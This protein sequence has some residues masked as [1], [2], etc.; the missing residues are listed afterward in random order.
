MTD[1]PRPA[2]GAVCAVFRKASDPAGPEVLLV[3]RRHDPFA[4]TW[5]LPGGYLD[6]GEGP[7]DAGPRELLE[8][9]GMRADLRQLRVYNEGMGRWV[10]VCGMFGTVGDDAEPMA[11]DD[12]EDARWWRVS[13][14]GRIRYSNDGRVLDRLS[15]NHDDIVR[16]ALVAMGMVIA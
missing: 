9:T 11:G 16:D 1:W 7:D 13:C 6:E 15:F 5:A 8:E 12:A 4:G 14:L 2:V 10:L 3:L